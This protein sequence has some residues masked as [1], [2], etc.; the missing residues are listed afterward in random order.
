MSQKILIADD[1]EGIHK[2][3]GVSLTDSGYQVFTAKNGEEALHVFRKEQPPIVLADIRMPVMDGIQLLKKIKE[4][5]PDTEVIMIT[6]HGDVELAIQSLKYEATDFVTKPMNDDSL[7]TALKRANERIFYRT[8]LREYTENLERL[9]EKY[10]T[11]FDYDPNS[12]FVLEQG[13]LRILDVNARALEVYCYEKHELIGKSLVDLGTA[14]YP[15]GVLSDTQPTEPTW[16]SEY[17]KVQ[18]YRK[19]GTP[20]YV[21]VYACQGRHSEEYGIIATTVDITDSLAKEALLIHASKMSTLGE[22]ATGVAHE[23]NQPLTAIQ[24]GADHFMN[25]VKDGKQIPDA[26]LALISEQ[27]AKQVARAVLTINHLREFGRKSEV[28]M[29]RIDINKPLKGVFTLLSHQLKMQGIKVVFD[30]NNDLPRVM[31]SSNRLEQVFMWLMLNARYAMEEKKKQFS[32][33]GLH[34]TL[35]IRSFQENDH[36]VVTIC[37][38]GVGIH[39]DVLNR[40]FEPFFTTKRV[41]EGAGLGLSI[42]YGIVKD[43]N[44]TI[45]VESELGTGTTFKLTFPACE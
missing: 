30:L 1:E 23:L 34:N 38:T 4:E 39:D 22:M 17:S 10:R 5:S 32:G 28:Q 26:E 18:H 27:M 19:D 13:T 7:E 42:S 15:D 6:G 29:E 36:V 20:F 43:Y 9:E 40:I 44:G 31:A 8:K 41:G 11:L 14:E 21:N 16:S 37:D 33:E 25:M 45:E 12:I 24:M 35:T 2:V 3:L